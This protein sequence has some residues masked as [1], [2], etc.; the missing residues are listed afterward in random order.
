MNLI[1]NRIGALRNAL[2][3]L[4]A[5]AAV[6]GW[7][8]PASAYQLSN[9]GNCH[10]GEKWDVSHLV[11]VRVLDDSVADYARLRGT[12]ASDVR[13]WMDRDIDAVIG[14]Y[15]AIAGSRLVLKR[16]DPITGDKDLQDTNKDDFGDQAIV[17]GFTNGV[18]DDDKTAEAVTSRNPEKCTIT[19]VHI[20]FRKNDDNNSRPF[21]W[22]FGPPDDY[23]CNGDCRSFSTR[24][25]PQPGG[26]TSE[27]TF[28][29][30]LTHEMGHAMGL[31][32]P[33]DDYA[34]M[35]QN[36][37][38]WF[39]GKNEVL[40]TQ[41]LPDD[42]SGVLALYGGANER[43]PLDIS[44]TNTWYKSDATQ[45]ATKC[46]AQIVAVNKASD[47]LAKA[48]GVPL[49]DRM[50]TPVSSDGGSQSSN[51]N[52]NQHNNADLLQA[53]TNASLALQACKDEQNA[54]QI[55]HCVVSSRAENWADL[56]RDA[57]KSCGVNAEHS[58]DPKV[59]DKVCPGRQIQLRYTLNNHTKL[60]DVRVRMEVWFSSD[61][62]LNTTDGSD[63]QSPLTSE[64]ALAAA[65]S[66]WDEGV[67][68]L[69]LKVPA[70]PKGRTYVF[71]RA[72]PLDPATHA[73]LLDTEADQFNNAVMV[74]HF[75][76]AD[77]SAC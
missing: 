1:R 20:R 7:V 74:R 69:P 41:L 47:A 17:I 2:L 50:A 58:A 39:R 51:Q 35:A 27:R 23:E 70:D 28:L 24:Q 55:E 15:N 5:A 45:F 14:L 40:H 9:P 12:T 3:P 18:F 61:M 11:Q 32:H 4:A 8:A 64:F 72:V 26:N 48:S 63:V 65:S 60:R 77:A 25:Q 29:G 16:G 6:L 33:D 36:S 44:V 37:R 52:T 66:K 62:V 46:A 42:T 54:M 13:E 75:I 57:G 59:S 38:T 71:V 19:R 68:S 76:K 67:W 21:V 22:V 56:V 53:L 31:D 43:V 34:L 49:G 10:P 30:I 73:S